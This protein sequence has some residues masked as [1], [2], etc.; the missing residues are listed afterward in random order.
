MSMLPQSSTVPMA[1]F[2]KEGDL[3]LAISS[4]GKSPNILNGVTAAKKAGCRVITF[5]GFLANNPLRSMGDLN[6]YVPSRAYGLVE[7]SHLLLI[8]AILR[9][10]IYLNPRANKGG[11]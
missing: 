9:E 4:S 11:Y 6:F 10:I 8:H 1:R 3:V 5:S 2:A 7:V